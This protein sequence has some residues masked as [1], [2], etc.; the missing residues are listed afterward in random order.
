MFSHLDAHAQR[1]EWLVVTGPS[2]SGKSTLLAVLLGF[3]RPVAGR[4]FLNGR[5]R[6]EMTGEV[7]RKRIAWCPQ[8]AHLFDSSLRANLLLARSREDAPSVE[9]MNEVL[10]W[11]ARNH[12]CLARLRQDAEQYR[13]LVTPGGQRLPTPGT[14]T[15]GHGI[16]SGNHHGDGTAGRYH[17]LDARFR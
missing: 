12:C 1:G 5:D 15:P 16:G 11:A 10:A 6:L 8:E 7:I 3:L 9:E 17:R 14:A 2:G 4:Y 13:R